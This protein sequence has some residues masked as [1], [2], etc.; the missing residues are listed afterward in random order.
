VNYPFNS[1]TLLVLGDSVVNYGLLHRGT[2]ATV[3]IPLTLSS[4]S[5]GQIYSLQ[6]IRVTFIIFWQ[7]R[8]R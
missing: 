2:H 7:C 6:H 5:F 4:S 1:L 3:G 8:G